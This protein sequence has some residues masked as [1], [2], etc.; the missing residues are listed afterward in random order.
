MEYKTMTFGDLEGA[1]SFIAGLKSKKIRID[2][3]SSYIGPARLS[4]GE[5]A[6]GIFFKEERY[7]LA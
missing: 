1:E 5:Y 7:K 6:I 3:F 2:G 4:N